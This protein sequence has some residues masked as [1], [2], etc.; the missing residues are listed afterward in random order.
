[1]AQKIVSKP[2]QALLKIERQIFEQNRKTIK[3]STDVK[4]K[5]FKRYHLN[6]KNAIKTYKRVASIEDV[7]TDL[8]RSRVII[9][10]DYHTLDQSQRSFVRVMR[11]LIRGGFKDFI[12][13]LET[14]QKKHQRHLDGFARDAITDQQ[15]IKKIGFKESWFFDL[16][17]NYAVIFD[18]LKYHEIPIFGIEADDHLNK[19]LKERDEFMAAEIVRLAGLYPNKKI[20]VLVGD[21]HLAPQHLP[22]EVTLRCKKKKL[23]LPI[24][25]LYQNS[26]EI[27]FK[28]S[29]KEVIDHAIIVKL[30]DRTYCRMHTP[31]IIVQQSYI[32]WLYH[33]EGR[34][35]WV[36]AKASFIDIVERIAKVTGMALSPGYDNVHV[37]TCGDLAFM[38]RPSFKKL[39]SKK[40]L[41]FIHRQIADSE[42]YFLPS[43]RIVYIANVS[44]NHAAEEA[45]HYLKFLM[46]GSEFPRTHRDA[47]YANVLHEAL[48]F[49][50]SKLINNKRK[51]YR[52]KDYQ[53]QKLFL[54]QGGM[55]LK[56]HVEYDTCV[57]FIRHFQMVK[58]RQLF[59]TNRISSFS[60]DLFLS[61]THAI[62]YDLGEHLYYGFM[63]GV[64]DKECIQGLYAREFQE[65]G[66]TGEE[67]LHLIE[68]LSRVKRPV[69]A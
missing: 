37:Y 8:N 47:F 46:T 61:L 9:V 50:G 16:W 31:P 22:R 25:T 63:E 57:L 17:D 36:D 20:F 32:N 23:T 55:A 3:D 68:A 10:G 21:L 14:V 35:D 2:R 67:Y 29:E 44:I 53:N 48:G 69:R 49:F 24:V 12:V 33:E 62:G 59:H 64:I 65:E 19:T 11:H 52:Y 18:F 15:L 51:C 7:E 42:S 54:E 40:E 58:K 4:D 13:L 1:M 6:Y 56:R 60:P 26:P 27:Y 43:A 45:S 30:A 66:A 28:L 5:N 39:F 34:F 41:K 38:K